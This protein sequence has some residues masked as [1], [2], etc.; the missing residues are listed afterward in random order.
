MLK[1]IETHYLKELLQLKIV[2]MNATF[3][4]NNLTAAT[5]DAMWKAKGISDLGHRSVG[6]YRASM[7]NAM[8]IESVH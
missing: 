2:L 6:G 5:F 4:L 7:Y 8:P 3:L 1:L